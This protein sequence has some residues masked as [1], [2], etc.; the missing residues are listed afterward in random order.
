MVVGRARQGRKSRYADW[1]DVYWGEPAGRV[2]V[3]ILGDRYRKVLK[4]GDLALV[5]EG[6]RLGVRYFEHLLPLSRETVN[7]LYAKVDA[8]GGERE[9]NGERELDRLLA[10]INANPAKLDAFLEAQHY[11]L[12]YWRFAATELNYRRF[13]D[14]NNLVAMRQEL[15]PVFDCSHE[16]VLKWVEDGILDGLRV[17][18]VDGLRDPESYLKRLRARAPSAWIV[19]EKNLEPDESLPANWPVDGTTG[20]EFLNMVGGLFVDPAG[21][22]PMTR[23][24]EHFAG[25]GASYLDV[26]YEKKLYILHDKFGS[27]ISRVA[28]L[29]FDSLAGDWRFRDTKKEEVRDLIGTLVACFPAYRTYLAPLANSPD[30]DAEAPPEHD[31]PL[32]DVA[33]QRLAEKRPDLDAELADVFKNILVRRRRGPLETELVG[34]FQQLTVPVTAKG[35]EDTAFYNYHRLL[36]LNEVGGDPSRFGIEPAAFHRWMYTFSQSH[37]R[38][39]LAT[40]THDTKR[41][42]DVRA[43]LALLSEIPA[44][45][46]R[47]VLSFSRLSERHRR[48]EIPELHTEYLFWQTLVGA[49]PI[50][51]DRLARYMLKAC[52][53]AKGRTA[54]VR[55]DPAYEESVL[56]FVNDVLADEVVMRQVVEFANSLVAAGRVNALAQK[57]ITLTAPG[58]PDIYQGTELWDLS[59]VDPDNRHPICFNL[60]RKL[61]AELAHLTIEEV[62]ARADEGLPKLLVVAR[63]LELRRLR[64]TLMGEG[65]AYRPLWAEGKKREHVVAFS[66]GDEVVT[67]VPRLVMRRG[68]DWYDTTLELPRG[69]FED[70]FTGQ[71]WTGRGPDLRAPPPL[72][73]RAPR[74]VTV[75]DGAFRGARASAGRPRPT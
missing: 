58:V 53:E 71:T 37:P 65:G 70:R 40:S 55:P 30:D 13:F 52:R 45:W 51:P 19:V 32:L 41:S 48:R 61:L 22:E 66:R 57:L 31:L 39:M 4:S 21:E 17:D 75:F 62:R 2:L 16:L 36:A 42:E 43:R 34:Q 73:G 18:H 46:T 56:C 26:A 44:E 20:Y 24:Y 3:P 67:V 14:I 27:E 47:A 8:E 15:A 54:W 9:T 11:K 74:E 60:R 49:H 25:N 72:P 5:R 6:P 10:T 23:A 38:S 28:Q 69:R 50:D 33:F 59:L 64:P 7:Y 63:A 1:F 68:D 12:S 35:V 29:L